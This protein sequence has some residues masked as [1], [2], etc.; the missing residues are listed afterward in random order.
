MNSSELRVAKTGRAAVHGRAPQRSGAEKR[1]GDSP[2]GG[3][4]YTDGK[5]GSQNGNSGFIQG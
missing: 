1:A 2:K 4:V 5:P 3:Q